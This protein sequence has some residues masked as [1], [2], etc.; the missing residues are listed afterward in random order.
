[1]IMNCSP[2]VSQL[3]L[4][5]LR[6]GL[7]CIRA[8]GWSGDA[9]RCA[10]EAD[11]IHNVPDLLAHFSPERLAFYWD[12]ERISYIKRTPP[13]QLEVWEPLWRKL[14]IELE[15]LASSTSVH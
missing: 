13:P 14:Q 5:M 15:A 11:H 1:M 3:L 6:T 10:I 7:L 4:E 9:E 12:V 2:E 8:L